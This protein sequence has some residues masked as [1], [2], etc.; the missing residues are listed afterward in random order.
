[1]KKFTIVFLTI[2]LILLTALIKNS[3]KRIDDEI[4]I[5]KEDIRVLKNDYETMK[6]E[7]NYLSSSDQLL[8]F[9]DLYFSNKLIKKYL[10]DM[11]I[12]DETKNG[13]KIEILNFVNE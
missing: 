5:L 12:I 7:Y 13:L 8:K 4:F 3:T 2:F 9:Q 10:D 11:K 1:M 6:L